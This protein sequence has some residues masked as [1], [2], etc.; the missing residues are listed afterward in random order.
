MENGTVM[1]TID[2]IPMGVAE[3]HHCSCGL[4]SEFYLVTIGDDTHD[5]PFPLFTTT[6]GAGQDSKGRAP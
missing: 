3:Q 5:T 1:L 4:L 2:R 6:T